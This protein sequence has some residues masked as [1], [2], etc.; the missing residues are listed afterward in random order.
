MLYHVHKVG[1]LLFYHTKADEFVEFCEDFFK[2]F[3][4]V[5]G[6]LTP[7]NIICSD[8]GENFFC[9]FLFGSNP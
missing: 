3:F 1:N 6:I 8:C 5:P 2:G 7:R 4:F 9:F